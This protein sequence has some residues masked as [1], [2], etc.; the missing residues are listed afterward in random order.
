MGYCEGGDL[1]TMLKHQRNTLLSEDVIWSHFVKLALALHYMHEQNI[2]H[3][4]LKAQNVFLQYGS[5]KLGDFG[6]SKELND[7]RDFAS[8]CIGTPYYMSPELFNNRPYNYKSDI[9]ALGC[10]LYELATLKHAF[11]APR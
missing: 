11:E 8:T 4:D 1:E 2:L 10:I 9:W 6:I 3:R 5:L 7:S